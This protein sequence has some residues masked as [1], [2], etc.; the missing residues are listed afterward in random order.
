MIDTNYDIDSERV[1]FKMYWNVGYFD[2]SSRYIFC[3][4]MNG[5]T[6]YPYVGRLKDISTCCNDNLAFNNAHIYLTDKKKG[7]IVKVPCN[8]VDSEKE[9]Y[10]TDG[11]FNK[12]WGVIS[13]NICRYICDAGDGNLVPQESI[14]DMVNLKY[15]ERPSSTVTIGK[16]Y[17]LEYK[18]REI[19]IDT[20]R[21]ISKRASALDDNRFKFVYAKSGGYVHD[22]SC[23]MVEKI[24][25]I[26]FDASDELPTDRDLCPRCKKKIYIR[27]SIMNDNK[28]FAWYNQFMEKGNVSCKVIEKI[29]S[30]GK[31]KLHMDTLS[32]LQVKCNEDT[33]IIKRTEN[34]KYVLY[35]NNY[36]MVNE[37]E[38]IITSGFHLQKCHNTSVAGIL[39][40]IESYNWYKHLEVKNGVEKMVEEVKEPEVESTLENTV[41][42]NEID[43]TTCGMGCDVIGGKSKYIE[44]KKKGVVVFVG[45]VLSAVAVVC[46]GV[47]RRCKNELY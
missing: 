37:T 47:R 18:G 40:Y 31:V 19:D 34:G 26:D 45:I 25:Y 43:V 2:D 21:L 29:L 32:E 7:T 5:Y 41:E 39:G 8:I 11:N 1:Y 44:K 38:R 14:N 30:S 42:K 46:F 20:Q 23:D 3:D 35:H 10:I 13:A 36:V 12:H 15:V 17:K 16:N 6:I 28:K 27:N 22:K 9:I 4:E 33:W 24:G